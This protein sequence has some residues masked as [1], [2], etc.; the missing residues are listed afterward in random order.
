MLVKL[1]YFK[2]WNGL[3]GKY[4]SSG[5]YVSEKEHYFE[6]VEEVRKLRDE[7]QLPGLIG[8]HSPDYHVLVTTEPDSVPH[9][10]I[11]PHFV[12]PKEQA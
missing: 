7:R 3:G 1:I 12:N 9:L 11:A 8:G 6:A 5:E 2:A 4:Y 10:L